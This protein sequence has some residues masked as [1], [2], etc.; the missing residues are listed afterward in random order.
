MRQAIKL[1]I[2]DHTFLR[3]ARTADA[4]PAKAL[5]VRLFISA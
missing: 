4:A 2:L 3:Q 5:F 1:A